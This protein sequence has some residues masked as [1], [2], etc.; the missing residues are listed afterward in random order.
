MSPHMDFLFTETR[1]TK[2]I[3]N[4]YFSKSF[5]GTHVGPIERVH[6]VGVLMS[7]Q[8]LVRVKLKTQ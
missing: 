5:S 1:E 7:P 6:L 8:C 2:L 3:L 4:F